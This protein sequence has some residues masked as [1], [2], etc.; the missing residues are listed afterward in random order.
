MALRLRPHP[1]IK[2]TGEG[3]LAPPSAQGSDGKVS[4]RVGASAALAGPPPPAPAWPALVRALPHQA[5][6]WGPWTVP[7]WCPL[8]SCGHGSGSRSQSSK[9]RGETPQ[10]VGRKI[11]PNRTPAHSRPPWGGGSQSGD[12]SRRTPG[13]LGTQQPQGTAAVRGEAMLTASGPSWAGP[14]SPAS[15]ARPGPPTGSSS[16]WGHAT[17]SVAAPGGAFVPERGGACNKGLRLLLARPG[18]LIKNNN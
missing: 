11:S 6:A 9:D 1:G 10:G 12:A 15:H 16:R 4:G 7:T 2:V 5:W 18:L 3:F 17:S 14:C 8:T 13:C